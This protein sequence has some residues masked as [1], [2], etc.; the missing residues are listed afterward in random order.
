MKSPS[1]PPF[2][3][4]EEVNPPLIPRIATYGLSRRLCK[5]DEVNPPFLKGAGGIFPT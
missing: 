5:G 4:G 3:K 2:S 1:Y